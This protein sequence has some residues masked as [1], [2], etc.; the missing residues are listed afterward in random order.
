MSTHLR[1]SVFSG[2]VGTAVADG[3]RDLMWNRCRLMWNE[4]LPR[5][6][7]RAMDWP[8]VKLQDKIR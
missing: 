5:S 8:D 6:T 3:R 7:P 2:A 1:R 4:R